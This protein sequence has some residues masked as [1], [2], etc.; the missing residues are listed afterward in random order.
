MDRSQIQ[1]KIQIVTKLPGIGI[2]QAQPLIK[3]EAKLRMQG[4]CM[5]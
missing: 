4:G 1:E 2:I 5:T 3:L